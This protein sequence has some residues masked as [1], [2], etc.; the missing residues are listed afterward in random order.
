MKTIKTLLAILAITA[1]GCTKD[2]LDER[3]SKSLLVPTT[4]PEMQALL[5]NITVM[6]TYPGLSSIAADEFIVVE[7]GATK[8]TA[9]ESG[10]YFLSADPYQGNAI[11]DWNG[12]YQQIF[13]A[14]VVLDGLKPGQMSDPSYPQVKGSALFF[15]AMALYNLSQLFM[16]P[17]DQNAGS[18]P[19]L[20]V[21]LN[22]NVNER[23]ERGNVR[24]TYRQMVTDLKA[25]ITLL[26]VKP[27]TKNRPSAQA[28]HALLA[29]IYLL[30]QD[31]PAAEEQANLALS[32]GSSLFELNTAA[33]T[34]TPFG[35]ALP[36]GIDEMIFYHLKVS[37]GFFS[38][39]VIKIEPGLAA[40]YSAN[41]LRR[42][43]YFR[44][45]TNGTNSNT[46][47]EG[48]TTGELLLIR[49]EC[50]ARRNELD[51]ALADLNTLLVKRWKTGTYVN[52]TAGSQETTLKL[53]FNERRKELVSRGLRWGDLRRMNLDPRFA[54]QVSR[55]YGGTPYILAPNSPKY[56]F[57]IPDKEIELGVIKQNKK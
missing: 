53:I 43:F 49:A 34:S 2:F 4:L 44:D 29:R 48:L 25:A 38:N 52:I 19:G 8:L 12:P 10:T 6:N 37:Y 18:N 50:R 45:L 24:D 22:S 47:F 32:I 31:Y 40:S 23:P 39:S 26:P 42:K 13:Y 51:Q 46:N 20:P 55:N 16:L 17:Y 35:K 33:A 21:P 27:A 5:D 57:P 28:A 56:V 54:T 30:M 36:N 14:N 3:P 15:R 11:S 7:T 9:V 1:L 41:D